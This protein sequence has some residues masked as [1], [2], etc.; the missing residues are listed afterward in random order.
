M[1]SLEPDPLLQ[2][3]RSPPVGDPPIASACV[4]RALR[5]RFRANRR[6]RSLSEKR[7]M[8][9]GLDDNRVIRLGTVLLLLAL[10]GGSFLRFSG[11][12]DHG[13]WT[14]ELFHVFAARSY[15][16]DGSLHVPWQPDEYERALPVTL[17]T[18][19]SFQIFGE[20][21]AAA[22]G[23][24]ALA[25]VLFMLI[26][27]RMV[28]GLFSRNVAILFVLSSAFSILGIQMSQECHFSRP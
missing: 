19:L 14:D 18:A 10:A 16:T 27:Y 8:M 26:G 7:E 12:G 1:G 22:R 3:R 25:N 11:I 6:E 28:K 21:E 24:F 20:S 4:Q 2:S 23:P 15:L 13:F 17:L 9:R 5:V